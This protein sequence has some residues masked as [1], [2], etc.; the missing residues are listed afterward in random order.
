MKVKIQIPP[1]KWYFA[2]FILIVLGFSFQLFKTHY[3]QAWEAFDFGL[4]VLSEEMEEEFLNYRLEYEIG[5]SDRITWTPAVLHDIRQRVKQEF[6]DEIIDNKIRQHGYLKIQDM[7]SGLTIYESPEIA[8]TGIMFVD[9]IKDNWGYDPFVY[10][11]ESGEKAGMGFRDIRINTDYFVGVV[12][13]SLSPD[14]AAGQSA[15]LKHV[16]S[17]M[18]RAVARDQYQLFVNTRKVPDALEEMHAWAYVYSITDDSLLWASKRM[19][20][21][22]YY[23]PDRSYVKQYL[24]KVSDVN[25]RR[26]KQHTEIF[27]K[28]PDYAYRVDMAMPYETV[29][30]SIWIVGIFIWGGA[31]FIIGVAFFGGNVL[32]RRALLPVKD[33]VNMVNKISEKSIDQRIP[34]KS[35]KPEVNHLIAT[36]NHLLD[37]LENAFKQQKSF[38]ADT[39]HELRTPLTLLNF[40]I[41]EIRKHLGCEPDAEVEHHLREAQKEI[42]RLARIVEDLQWLAKNDAGQ[43]PVKDQPIRLDE[44]LLE[45]MSLCQVGASQRNIRLVG[46]SQVAVEY[47][48]DYHLLIRAYSN[49]VNNAIKYSNE[50]GIVQLTLTRNNTTA[51]LAVEDNGIGIPEKSLEHIFDRFYRVDKSRSRAT[52]GSG[53]GLSIARQ[54]A[55]L[56]RGWIQVRSTEGIGSLF[57]IVLP[58]NHS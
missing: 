54:I 39:S 22:N 15:K 6:L 18:F 23:V 5:P 37:R 21:H 41:A 11:E 40:D 26:F 31:I 2:L 44:V 14:Q 8:Q 29:R 17:D 25:G 20:K 36:F 32:K 12:F 16:T 42:G 30:S 45:T 55:E 24:A 57:T 3:K 13:D 28:H 47:V 49:L 7:V 51:A 48:G 27:D 46:N 4:S 33:V 56:H 1:Y 50:G 38:I 34:T 43:L 52:G 9:K 19:P 35:V 10:R 53:L 58:C